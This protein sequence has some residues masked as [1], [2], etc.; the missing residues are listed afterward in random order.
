MAQC[1]AD[2]LDRNSDRGNQ[3]KVLYPDDMKLFDK[4]RT[5][6]QEIYGAE[7]IIAD[8]KLRNK[9]KRLD[10]EYKAWNLPICMAKTQYSLSSDPSLMGRPRN[11]V[12]PVKD[13]EVRT[14]AGFALVLTGDIMTMPGLPV[15]P[16]AESIDV[17]AE[18]NITGLF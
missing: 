14:G 16:A 2:E 11:F 4:V 12:V 13:V 15:V 17:D 3:F 5:I 8:T 6:A 18:G 10:K 9:F 7:D 1:V